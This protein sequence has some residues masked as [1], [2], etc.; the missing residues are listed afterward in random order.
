MEGGLVRYGIYLFCPSGL[1]L[2]GKL[3]GLDWGVFCEG[4]TGRKFKGELHDRVG[5]IE[6]FFLLDGCCYL[7]WLARDYVIPW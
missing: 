1:V 7:W 2:G 5:N 4:D 6:G 3:G